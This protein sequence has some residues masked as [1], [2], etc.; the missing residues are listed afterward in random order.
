[1]L[2]GHLDAPAVIDHDGIG[3][4]QSQRAVGTV[5]YTHLDV[6]KRQVIAQVIADRLCK[7][8]DSCRKGQ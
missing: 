5:S 4:R 6:Y 8:L 2:H 1:M 3:V 7:W